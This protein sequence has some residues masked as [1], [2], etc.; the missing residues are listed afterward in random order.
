MFVDVGMRLPFIITTLIYCDYNFIGIVS[1]QKIFFYCHPIQC[2]F[3]VERWQD[4]VIQH[5]HHV[6][7][8]DHV[9]STCI[10]VKSALSICWVI[11][12]IL[13]QYYILVTFFIH[14]NFLSKP[15]KRYIKNTG[16]RSLRVLYTK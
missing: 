1:Y 4:D 10:N 7:W 12:L 8:R 2:C 3:N 5:W 13:L 16:A 9:I 6:E 11:F 15:A 14:S